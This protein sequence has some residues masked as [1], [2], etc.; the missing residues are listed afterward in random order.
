[1]EQPDTQDSV[2]VDAPVPE[3][4]DIPETQDDDSGEGS[5]DLQAQTTEEDEL[6]EELEGVKVRGKK[7]LIEKLKAERLMQ[8]DYTR[9]TQEVAEQRKAFETERAQHQQLTR[10]YLGEVA[11][12]VAVDNR[13]AQFAKADWQALSDQDPAQAQKLW[14]EFQQ[15]QGTKNQLIQNLTQ[16]QQQAAMEEQ[17][18]SAK[19]LQEAAAAVARDIKGW[20]PELQSKLTATAKTNGYSDEEVRSITD[21]RA[22]KLLHKA[23]LYDQ[24]IA[25]RKPTTPPA[26]PPAPV[27][28]VSGA[29]A[30]V[31]R[32]LSQMTDAE[33]A[34]ARRDYIAKHR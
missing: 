19:R 1:M 17:H 22:V 21:P 29:G 9:K 11:Q 33:Y 15:L 7:D 30:T 4:Q 8:A 20:S 10:A 27:A 26:T 5:E 12:I 3:S 16:K 23:Y 6:E 31:Q 2:V 34:K 13:L 32:K 18:T 25:Q 14:F 28:R 24:L